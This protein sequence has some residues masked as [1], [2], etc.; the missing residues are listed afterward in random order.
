MGAAVVIW[1]LCGG[2]G[3]SEAAPA[4]R[5]EPIIHIEDVALFYRV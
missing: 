2:T 1:V 3:R 5:V 4:K